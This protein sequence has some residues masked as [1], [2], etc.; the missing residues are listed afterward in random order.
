MNADE[1]AFCDTPCYYIFNNTIF[2]SLFSGFICKKKNAF[3]NRGTKKGH[4]DLIFIH[5]GWWLWYIMYI[6]SLST[7]FQL[8]R[9][10][11]FYW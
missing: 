7:I 6:M 3:I 1:S 5:G 9:G 4:S 11:Q 8:Y 10:G 2:L